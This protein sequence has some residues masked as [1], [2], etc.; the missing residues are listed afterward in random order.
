MRNQKAYR[1]FDPV[2]QK[3]VVSRDVIFEEDRGWEWDNNHH[4]AAMEDLEWPM[5]E[6]EDIEVTD[7][8][9]EDG[10]SDQ[11][12]SL[13]NSSNELT[14]EDSSTPSEGRIRRQPIWMRDYENGQ[15]LSEEEDMAYLAMFVDS[16]PSNFV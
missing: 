8:S 10:D 6:V 5:E 4:K 7:E 14:N 12:D 16:D 15:G 1:L 13:D 9:L 11:I 3:I 2:S